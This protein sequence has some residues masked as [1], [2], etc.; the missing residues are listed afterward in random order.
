MSK[1]LLSLVLA[2]TLLISVVPVAFSQDAAPL[3]NTDILMM[4]RA[5]LPA[6]L[7]VKKINGVA[8]GDAPGS[9]RGACRT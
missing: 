8:V 5:K 3:T 6:A 1:S 2:V 7:I 9:W 4:V